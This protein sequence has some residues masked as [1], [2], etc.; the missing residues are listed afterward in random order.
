MDPT[1]LSKTLKETDVYF[2]NNLEEADYHVF[3]RESD[4]REEWVTRKS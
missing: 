1:L 3:K 4:G 2:P